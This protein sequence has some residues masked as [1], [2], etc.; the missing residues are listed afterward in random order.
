MSRYDPNDYVL[1]AIWTM[2]LFISSLFLD[3]TDVK[4]I[5]PAFIHCQVDILLRPEK[6]SS[7]VA[8]GEYNPVLIGFEEGGLCPLGKEVYRYYQGDHPEGKQDDKTSI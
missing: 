3:D 1:I 8:S 5:R 6:E 7:M 2:K 4:N